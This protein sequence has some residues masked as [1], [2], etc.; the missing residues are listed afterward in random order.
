MVREVGISAGDRLAARQVLG[1]ECLPIRR[2][3]EFRLR[4]GRRRAGPQRG[5]GLDDLLAAGGDGDMDVVGLKDATQVRP[6]R[7]ALPQ[8]LEG[9]LLVAEGLQEGEWELPS[10]ER[11]LGE[12]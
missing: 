3:D 9:R 10:A 4:P 7:L 11:L 6:V 5:Q 1:L 12:R 2:Q 8:A